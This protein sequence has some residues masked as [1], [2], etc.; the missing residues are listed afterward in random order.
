VDPT[1]CFYRWLA[2]IEDDLDEAL[3]AADDLA[4]WLQRGG[5]E[6]NWTAIQRT[7]FFN[8]LHIHS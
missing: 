3:A 7:S 1:A 4:H 2:A 8:W 5:F 6:P